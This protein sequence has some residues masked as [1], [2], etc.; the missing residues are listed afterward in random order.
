MLARI[1]YIGIN[2]V[3]GYSFFTVI[4]AL[5]QYRVMFDSVHYSVYGPAI[6]A[7]VVCVWTCH[8]RGRRVTIYSE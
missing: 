2:V 4:P 3:G 1:W 8:C 5:S 7:V 6:V